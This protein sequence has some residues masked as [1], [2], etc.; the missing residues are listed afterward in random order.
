[1]RLTHL[2][3]RTPRAKGKTL[4]SVVTPAYNESRNLPLLYRG[5]KKNLEKLR[6]S[7]EWIVV[8]DHSADGTYG[9]VEKIARRDQRVKILR[10]AKNSGS[11]LALACG[12]REAKGQC[13]VGMAADLQDPPETIGKLVEKWRKGAQ[14]IWAVRGKREGENFSTLLF[15]RIYYFVVRYVVGIKQV[16]PTGA[17]YFLLDRKVLEALAAANVKN[18]SL[19][20]L[21]GSLPFRQDFILYAKKQ[22]FFGKS[23]WN[24]RKKIKLF[25]V[26]ISMFS[27]APVY[28]M[29]GIGC[30]MGI[31][32]L[33]LALGKWNDIF[34]P[35]LGVLFS[36]P[37]LALLG[38]G[39]FLLKRP[40]D[41]S[42][43]PLFLIEKRSCPAV[44]VETIEN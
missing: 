27:K 41:T 10:F 12:F 2:T 33:W 5:L 25:L 26:S 8:D 30:G 36:V 34:F 7:W 15:S 13:A 37:A 38:T 32:G 22:R 16:P 9:I 18:A 11:H 31:T 24:L 3:V 40:K 44:E 39:I 6:L 14:V 19:L 23:G 21:I 43:A 42:S 35:I 1:M 29:I 20:L 4:L 28:W 17:D